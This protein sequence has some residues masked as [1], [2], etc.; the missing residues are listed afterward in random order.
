MKTIDEMKAEYPWQEAMGEMSGFGG[1]YEDACR[2]M[3]YSGLAW[4]DNQDPSPDLKGSEYKGVT[5]IF[6]V[7]S[8]DAKALEDAVL[9]GEPGCSGA[10]HHAAMSACFYIAKNGWNKYVEAMIARNK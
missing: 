2:N 10:M 1:G 5:G 4:L 6:N 8:P 3:L 9:E 7:E